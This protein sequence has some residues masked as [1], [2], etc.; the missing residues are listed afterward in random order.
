[1]LTRYL[2]SENE[3]AVLTDPKDRPDKHY[4]PT[5]KRCDSNSLGSDQKEILMAQRNQGIFLL[6]T[7]NFYSG[8]IIFA[9]DVAVLTIETISS[10]LNWSFLNSF[11]S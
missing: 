10:C 8:E 4:Y 6:S 11:I 1:M 2:Y 3:N 7:W 9:T 5:E